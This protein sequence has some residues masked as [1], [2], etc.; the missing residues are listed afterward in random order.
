MTFTPDPVTHELVQWMA[1]PAGATPDGKPRLS[2][3][4]SPRLYRPDDGWRWRLGA[5]TSFADWPRALRDTIT[6]E[7]EL[8]GFGS[9]QCDRFHPDEIDADRGAAPTP[10][11][12]SVLWASLFDSDFIVEP[13][14][15]PASATTKT[16][17]EPLPEVMSYSPSKIASFVRDRYRVYAFGKS[18]SK[19]IDI[20]KVIALASQ[21]KP[22]RRWSEII[23][24]YKDVTNPE[25]KGHHTDRELALAEFLLF[26]T[27]PPAP[28]FPRRDEK[29]KLPSM[30]SATGGPTP[31]VDED[32]LVDP[33]LNGQLYIADPSSEDGS[34]RIPHFLLPLL[35][36]VKPG[37]HVTVRSVSLCKS[38]VRVDS[39]DKFIDGSTVREFD[40]NELYVVYRATSVGWMPEREGLLDFHGAV[41]AMTAYPPLLRRL[42][43]LLDFSLRC[44]FD[45]IAKHPSIRIVP[46]RTRTANIADVTPWTRVVTAAAGSVRI[47]APSSKEMTNGLLKTTGRTVIQTD[48]DGPTFKAM[49][50]LDRD[51]APALRH[52]GVA[53]VDDATAEKVRQALSAQKAHVTAFAAT[54]DQALSQT[55]STSQAALAPPSAQSVG[56]DD[57]VHGY[58]IDVKRA[59]R[60]GDGVWRPLCERTVH[61]SGGFSAIDEGQIGKAADAVGDDKATALRV[62]HTLFR[63]D[64][65]SL[66]V[67]RPGQSLDSH[68]KPVAGDGDLEH[69]NLRVKMDIDVGKAALERLRFG[70]DYSFRA[71]AV[72]A[73]GNGISSYEA[74]QLFDADPSLARKATFTTTFYRFE[75]I[76]TPRLIPT[77]VPV[78]GETNERLVIRTLDDQPARPRLW[79]VAPPKVAQNLAEMCGAMDHLTADESH[80]DIVR[81][82]QDVPRGPITLGPGGRSDSFQY[83]AD[84]YCR[85]IAVDGV[86]ARFQPIGARPQFDAGT[87]AD[88]RIEITPGSAH[89]IHRADEVISISVPP[90]RWSDHEL[91]SFADASDVDVFGLFQWLGPG[92]DKN[93]VALGKFDLVTPHRIITAVHA[94]QRPLLPRDTRAIKLT[95]DEIARDFESTTAKLKWQIH[96]DLPS[97]GRIDMQA[98]WN[99]IVDDPVQPDW[100]TAKGAARPF[101]EAIRL[102]EVLANKKLEEIADLAYEDEHKFADTH[103]HEVK[104]AGAV[105]TR[106]ADNF[107]KVED[108][109]SLTRLSVPVTVHVP[110]SARPKV[111]EIDYIV[112]TFMTTEERES[113]HVDR[114]RT[115]GFRVYM[116]RGWFSSGNDEMLAV[117][118]PRSS[119]DVIDEETQKKM[120]E[121]GMDPIWRSEPLP[122]RPSLD[123]FNAP[124]KI[125]SMP[126]F[127]T[128]SGDKLL[129][130]P[131]VAI[132]AYPV[133]LDKRKNKVYCDV[134]VV[135]P[136][137][138]FPFIRLALARYQPYSV[139]GAH[140]SDVRR[141]AF[142][143]LLPNRT[144]SARRVGRHRY[145]IAVAGPCYLPAN[146]T[147]APPGRSEFAWNLPYPDMKV[148]VERRTLHRTGLGWT[149]LPQLTRQLEGRRTGATTWVWEGDID[150]PAD[151]ETR[152]VVREYEHFP[153][154]FVPLVNGQ[155]PPVPDKFRL[156]YV[157]AI[158]L[159][160]L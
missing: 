112:P 157:D 118:L 79:V 94:T 58:R 30:I 47:F 20:A 65:W 140:L 147:D 63:W 48:D 27:A 40:R 160:R 17:S 74:S 69:P 117:V 72:D 135:A 57:V 129:P 152:L 123:Y 126:L 144:L 22:F 102:P 81:L 159:C 145:H 64:G 60:G 150:V 33:A 41:S 111:P 134:D 139:C 121:W 142:V 82:D 3:F 127:Y 62:S 61:Y 26:H 34:V 120:S 46:H 143:Q 2:V 70:G 116:E 68:G 73:A 148:G 89:A 96:V 137:T 80:R 53:V 50:E 14:G 149:P 77:H 88:L 75:P 132:A 104:Y 37:F 155:K 122:P 35:S 28:V 19:D 114:R 92:A 99:D 84:P 31:V 85:G 109:T 44:T 124:V 105:T 158:E 9:V 52:A 86:T 154:D 138:Y 49:L 39:G 42:G 13:Y 67:P 136:H 6:F 38:T 97:S 23:R 146:P 119:F 16:K 125:T 107:E 32:V 141:A 56:G 15:V 91:S 11:P 78:S 25:Q 133:A 151:G 106:F 1:L 83:V 43:L 130:G 76:L 12:S 66:V 101:Q 21:E 90:G 110:N 59:G 71:R 113:R 10:D 45:D 95:I 51:E 108:K 54:V 103:H 128:K 153:V 5:A 87:F 18:D 156:T 29:P 7:A 36:A 4:V 24:R 98:D 131:D 115:S 8:D 55:S 100:T 93:A